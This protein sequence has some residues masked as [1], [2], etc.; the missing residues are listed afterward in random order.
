MA[1]GTIARIVSD[2]GFG[3]VKPDGGGDDVFF[4]HSGVTDGGYD[5]LREGQA[6][7][8]ETGTDERSNR[9]RAQNVR[10]I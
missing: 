4:H 3:F 9:A 6:V 5:L 7:E 10:P 2:R 8:Y 1:Q